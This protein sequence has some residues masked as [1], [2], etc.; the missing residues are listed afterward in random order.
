MT[1]DRRH[2]LSLIFSLA[3]DCE[4]L[5]PTLRTCTIAEGIDE[6]MSFLDSSEALAIVGRARFSLGATEFSV[7]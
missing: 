1:H 3:K 5:R 7:S 4:Y 2:F 6:S